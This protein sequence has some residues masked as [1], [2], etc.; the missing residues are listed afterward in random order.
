MCKLENI[1]WAVVKSNKM[2]SKSL[3][4]KLGKARFGSV[5]ENTFS[6][7]YFDE[8]DF[9]NIVSILKSYSNIKFEVARF[10]DRQF[11]LTLNSW[12][13]RQES[14]DTNVAKLPLSNKFSWF[15]E[16]SQRISVTPI[17]SKQF[18]NILKIN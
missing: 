15:L 5:Q 13:G 9:D 12:T 1:K 16:T 4:S 18:N 11:G 2:I 6:F 14:F 7:Y 8:K 17:T 3:S 10:Y